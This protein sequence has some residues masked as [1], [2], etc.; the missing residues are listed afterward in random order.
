VEANPDRVILSA[1]HHLLKE[2][3]VAS[4]PWEGYRRDGQ[5]DWQGHYHGYFPDGGP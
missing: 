2:T 1:H 5:G 4:D 3:T